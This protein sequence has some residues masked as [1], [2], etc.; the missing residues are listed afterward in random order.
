LQLTT[1]KTRSVIALVIDDLLYNVIME[2][3]PNDYDVL[4]EFAL[5]RVAELQKELER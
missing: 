5:K 4:K 3:M 2:I 1:L